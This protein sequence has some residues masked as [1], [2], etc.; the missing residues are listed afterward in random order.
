MFF[1]A[2]TAIASRSAGV[3]NSVTSTLSSIFCK[4]AQLKRR[5]SSDLETD[6]AVRRSAHENPGVHARK[7]R[8]RVARP[9]GACA[10]RPL[11]VCEPGA[12]GATRITTTTRVI[13][14]IQVAFYSPM[15]RRRIPPQRRAIRGHPQLRN[16]QVLIKSAQLK[17]SSSTD[18]EADLAN[19]RGARRHPGMHAH[20]RLTS[21]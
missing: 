6:S 12:R 16:L 20:T 2:V 21:T 17:R 14:E 3:R 8:P 11:L 15:Q 13:S 18:G 4:S 19:R 9:R 7:T 5:S 1:R 10:S